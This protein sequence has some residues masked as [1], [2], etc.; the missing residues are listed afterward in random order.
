M[1]VGIE[2]EGRQAWLLGNDLTHD[3]DGAVCDSAPTPRRWQATMHAAA[4]APVA[5]RPDAA[6]TG[7]PTG[8]VCT[9]ALDRSTTLRRPPSVDVRRT[10]INVLPGGDPRTV[11]PRISRTVS[12]FHQRTESR[13]PVVPSTALR[14]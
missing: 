9:C 11:G 7:V 2:V 8:S 3:Y 10:R 6:R 5:A 12:G 1:E 13:Q 4:G 14:I